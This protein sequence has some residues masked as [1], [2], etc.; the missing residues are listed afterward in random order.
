MLDQWMP[1]NLSASICFCLAVLAC[2]CQQ[3]S[4]DKNPSPESLD[5][6]VLSFEVY[7]HTQGF[8]T[9]LERIT[10]Q[11]VPVTID[12]S[13]LD[14][15]GV[16]ENRMVVRKGRFGDR[17]A[18][19]QSGT[20]TFQAPEQDESYTLYLMNASNGVD[21]RKVDTWTSANEGILEYIPPLQWYRED[22]NGMTGPEDVILDAISQLNDALDYPWAKYGT[23][24]RIEER[25]NSSFGVGYGHCRNQFGWHNPYWAGVNPWHCA[26][27]KMKLATFLE[28]IFELLTRLNDIGGKD[29]ASLI[30]DPDTGNLNEVGKDLLAYVFVKDEKNSITDSPPKEGVVLAVEESKQRRDARFAVTAGTLP[31]QPDKALL[32]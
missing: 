13:D 17:V 31:S 16:E 4:Q 12:M 7:N 15:E 20:A 21:Y 10:L 9:A 3:N 2:A 25:K 29:T 19:S 14:V 27:D 26:T 18:F 6:V 1:K 24:Q 23:I 5:E 22:R 8:V 32:R 11:E 28:E 30:T